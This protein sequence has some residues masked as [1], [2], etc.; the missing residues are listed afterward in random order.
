MKQ[1]KLLKVLCAI[2]VSLTFLPLA[3]ITYAERVSDNNTILTLFKDEFGLENIPEKEI[4]GPSSFF[5]TNDKTIYV[6]DNLNYEIKQYKNNSIIKKINYD[7]SISAIDI[8]I[9]NKN[10]IYLLSINSVY[11]LNESGEIVKTILIPKIEENSYQYQVFDKNFKDFY[12]PKYIEI[13][14]EAIIITFQ[15]YKIQYDP[16]RS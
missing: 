15:N 11:I 5:I 9:K 6:L 7:K 12:H 8:F 3:N 4:S 10:T 14:N 16:K 13:E 1:K 2:L